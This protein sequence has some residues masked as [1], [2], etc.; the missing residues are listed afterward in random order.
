MHFESSDIRCNCQSQFLLSSN[1]HISYIDQS[2]YIGLNCVIAMKFNDC[3]V[4]IK[5]S[6][7]PFRFI[8]FDSEI[9][10]IELKQASVWG[11]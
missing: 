10:N 11:V 5:G 4:N 3:M 8:L 9:R 7:K 1:K 2:E 6:L